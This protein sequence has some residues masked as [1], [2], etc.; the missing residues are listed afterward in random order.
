[1]KNRELETRIFLDSMLRK[2][3]RAYTGKSRRELE[4]KI[5]EILGSRKLVLAVS[6]YN[7][8]QLLDLD[9]DELSEHFFKT[10][11]FSLINLAPESENRLKDFLTPYIQDLKNISKASNIENTRLSRLLSGEFINL[12]PSE[13]YGLAKSF[14]LNPSQL[15]DY[16]YGD[17]DRPVVGL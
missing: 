14:G 4:A 16:L 10:H 12:Y 13:V 17:G 5:R 2:L 3:A 7:V 6:F 9:I 15:F 11:S 1:M 8:I